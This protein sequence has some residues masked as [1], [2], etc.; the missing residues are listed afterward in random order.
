MSASV[1]S[2]GGDAFTL[3]L[4]D[5]TENWTQST[6]A[7]SPGAALGSAEVIAEAPSNGQQ[8]LPLGNFGTVDF[9]GATVNKQ[10]LASESGLNAITMASQAGTLA[11]PSALTGDNAFT[12]TWENSGVTTTTTTGTGGQGGQGGQ[13]SGGSGGQGSGG[14]GQGSGGSG[15]Q[16]GQGGYGQGG[17]GGQGGN[18]GWTPW[19]YSNGSWGGGY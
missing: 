17:Q 19:G 11:T 7:N 2:D 9:T 3:T 10:A 1:V 13:G 16:G 15:G 14:G 5:T 18:G 8:V 12:V 6:K 4:S